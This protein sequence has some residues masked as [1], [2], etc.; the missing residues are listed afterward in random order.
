M[1]TERAPAPALLSSGS[2]LPHLSGQVRCPGWD[3]LPTCGTTLACHSP[4]RTRLPSPG[5]CLPGRP[6]AW[7]QQAPSPLMVLQP[8]H[9]QTAC[10]GPGASKG[11]SQ[12]VSSRLSGPRGQAV[13]TVLCPLPGLA[14][15]LRATSQRLRQ[16]GPLLFPG[17]ARP[18]Q[19]PAPYLVRGAR[20]WVSSTG[21]PRLPPSGPSL[22]PGQ[23]CSQR[24]CPV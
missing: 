16:E 8:F 6:C 10:P 24:K 20:P 22:P 5:P 7:H 11:P 4:P 3:L 12:A 9:G 2:F 17:L 23:Y 18:T 13:T 15:R 21:V 14:R 1:V 19:L